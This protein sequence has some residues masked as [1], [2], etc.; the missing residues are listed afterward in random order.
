[1]N[2]GSVHVYHTGA[3][4]NTSGLDCWC[5]PTYN[6]LCDECDVEDHRGAAQGHL[7]EQPTHPGCWKCQNGLIP[8]SRRDA[9]WETS[10]LIIVHNR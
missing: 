4:H 1:M 5:V 7:L 6:L 3:E 10:P 8:V 2:P 9:E